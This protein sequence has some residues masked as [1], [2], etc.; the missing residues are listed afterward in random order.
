MSHLEVEQRS[1]GES[2]P[3]EPQCVAENYQKERMDEKKQ[4]GSDKHH[5]DEDTVR[6]NMTKNGRNRRTFVVRGVSSC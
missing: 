4:Q 3:T 5:G 2:M 6:E 1:H